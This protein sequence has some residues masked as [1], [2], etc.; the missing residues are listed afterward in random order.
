VLKDPIRV[1][2]R[3]IA[4]MERL[5]AHRIAEPDD[6]NYACQP[7]TAGKFVNGTTDRVSV[8]RPLQ[9]VSSAHYAMFCDCQ[10]WV[11]HWKE[12]QQ[13]CEMDLQTRLFQ[14]PYNFMTNSF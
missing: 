3:Q 11:S 4:E 14:H 8:A 2:P 1:H 13:W 5:L 6:P 9:S 10:R 12:D 7:D